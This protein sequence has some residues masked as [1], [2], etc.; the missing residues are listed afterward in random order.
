MGYRNVIHCGNLTEG[1][2][3]ISN[4]YADTVFLDGTLRQVNYIIKNYP[5]IEGMKTYLI[6]GVKDEKHLFLATDKYTVV[7]NCK[8]DKSVSQKKIDG[9][10][11]MIEALGIYLL[12]NHG[13]GEIMVF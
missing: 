1:L 11:A 12:D 13:T 4:I 9:V 5:K 2:F 3:P 10:I 8:P 6:T 7:G